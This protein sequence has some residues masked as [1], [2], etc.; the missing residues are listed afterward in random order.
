MFGVRIDGTHWLKP[1]RTTSRQPLCPYYTREY[2]EL[3]AY[4][5]IPVHSRWEVVERDKSEICGD[6]EESVFE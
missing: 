1:D 3:V 5:T 6:Y 2:A 4:E